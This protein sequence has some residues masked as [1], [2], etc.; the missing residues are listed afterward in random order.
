MLVF[1]GDKYEEVVEKANA[2]D[3]MKKN[4][5]MIE[6]CL[7]RMPPEF[8]P[9]VLVMLFLDSPSTE[10]FKSRF[11]IFYSMQPINDTTR[12]MPYF[13]SNQIYNEFFADG[14]R[15]LSLAAH[16]NQ[17][18]TNSSVKNAY[19]SYLDFTDPTKELGKN[20]ANCSLYMDFHSCEGTKKTRKDET[21]YP[22]RGQPLYTTFV[23][24][25]WQDGKYDKEAFKWV[26]ETREILL[27][28]KIKDAIILPSCSNPPEEDIEEFFKL[29]TVYGKENLEKLKEVKKKYDPTCFFNKWVPIKI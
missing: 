10:E 25:R 8:Y 24:I 28:D 13:E 7:T 29:E 3:I 11:N 16:I 26:Y 17:P 27:G 2:L 12:A 21:V 5:M 6:V 4:D 18:F 15:K 22:S 9:V 23:N 14:D 19:Q 20:F 1:P